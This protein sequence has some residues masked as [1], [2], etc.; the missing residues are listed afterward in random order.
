MNIILLAIDLAKQVLQLCGLN[1]AGAVVLNKKINR[2]A[3]LEWLKDLAPTTVAMEACATAHHWG[4]LLQA[5]GHTVRLI[6]AQ[7]VKA[8][9][10]VH[11]TDQGDALAIAEAAQRPGIHW[12]PVKTVNQQDLQML[13]RVR[14]Q[15]VAQRTERICQIRGLAA[16]Y[17]VIFAKSR[18]KVMQELPLALEDAENLLTPPHGVPW[19]TSM[20]TSKPSMSD[21][22][23]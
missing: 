9:C 14:A 20:T 18:A 4:R 15:L 11:K 3:F 16:E 21:C 7:H 6:P 2:S 17:G 22:S 1:P 23:R 13:G 19:L 12:V 10:R 5:R 8:F